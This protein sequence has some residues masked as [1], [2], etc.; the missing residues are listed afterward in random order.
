M[1]PSFPRTRRDRRR[2]STAGRK[3]FTLE[4]AHRALPL[5]RRIVA[6]IV[7][8]HARVLALQTQDDPS[9]DDAE[10]RE[11]ELNADA[12]QALERLRE[13]VQE[14]TAVGCDLKDLERGLVDFPCMHEGR[15]VCLCWHLGEE[16]IDFWHEVEAGFAGR[17]PIDAS[18]HESAPA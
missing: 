2:R 1:D 8:Q 15:E 16:R 9:H 13:F 6:D 7:D 12:S 17:Q 18:F 14:L 3:F 10:D 11:I 4:Q 5:V